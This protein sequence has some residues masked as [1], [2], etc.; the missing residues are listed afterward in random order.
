MGRVLS[1]TPLDLVDLL[2]DFEGLEIVEFWLV[3]L[4]LGIEL[5]LAAFFLVIRSCDAVR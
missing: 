2:L 5:V 1:F 3:R 4:E